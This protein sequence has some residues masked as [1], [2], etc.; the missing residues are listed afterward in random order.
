MRGVALVI[1]SAFFLSLFSLIPLHSSAY[2]D[3][4]KPAF[5][6]Q[7]Y[8]WGSPEARITPYP[9]GIEVPL[10]LS[11][12]DLL[13]FSISDVMVHVNL[14][15]GFTSPNGGTQVV[16]AY[17]SIP[18]LSQF[19]VNLYLNLPQSLRP[20][21]YS[22]PVLITWNNGT[23]YFQSSLNSTVFVGG[24]PELIAI[25]SSNVLQPGRTNGINLVLINEGTGNLSNL[26]LQ[27][28]STSPL[29]SILN[30]TYNINSLPPNSSVTLPFYL[31]VSSSAAGSPVQLQLQASYLDPY[32]QPQSLSTQL[33][34][35]VAQAEQPL[36]QFSVEPLTLIP[37]EVN[38][39]RLKVA[40]VGSGN[41]SGL[42]FS[43][44]S[45][46]QVSVLS[47]P[48]LIK[49]LSVGSTSALNLSVYAPLS[50]AGLGVVLNVQGTART[51]YGTI[52][53]SQLLD[54]QVSNSLKR[55]SLEI[56]ASPITLEPDRV[57]QVNLTVRNQ[58]DGSISNLQTEL[59]SSS[60]LYAVL[61]QP[62]IVLSLPPNSSVTLPFYLF[63]SS[64]AA[65]S[66]VQLQLQASY[67]DPYGQPQSLSTQLG[68]SVAQAEQSPV[69]VTV[70]QGKALIGSVSQLSFNLT[71][72]GSMS[73]EWVQVS[74]QIPAGEGIS[75]IPTGSLFREL[76]P[77]QTVTW[78]VPIAVSPNT[79]E[80]GYSATLLVDYQD[81]LGE[82][83]T[84]QFPV[85]FLV[86]GQ[87]RL[88]VQGQAVQ[89]IYS[90]PGR[91]ITVSGTL[92]NEGSTA[93]YYTVVSAYLEVNG[94]VISNS[95]TYVGEVETNTPLPFS[96]TLRY[97]GPP[98][99][100]KVLVEAFYQ[101][102]FGQ[103]FTINLT[104]F[105]VQFQSPPNSTSTT[106]SVSLGVKQ[107]SLIRLSLGIVILAA[108]I[109]SILYLRRR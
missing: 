79:P 13:N 88:S 71:N 63:V 46:S 5:Q 12:Q 84:S 47:G 102:D 14:S 95:S 8:F 30:S 6:F 101:N 40:N 83:L 37:G 53:V 50:V 89:Q 18:P 48:F 72:T 69:A 4:D 16:Q 58:G 70:T 51:D 22:F 15:N 57:Q 1:V 108:V 94:T 43:V 44:N 76:S 66:P 105:Q 34:F 61:A 68:F 33:G 31:F 54:L 10:T 49:E 19:Q 35:S 73:I 55:V 97:S 67:L 93:A 60:P 23:K 77:G 90:S 91:E 106:S 9:G 11:F 59:I 75:V 62:P 52:Q 36:L 2:Q 81:Q 27:L 100:G 74:L 104:D 24:S 82:H 3:Y 39:L 17:P 87:V 26:H 85:G 98:T 109:F 56:T 103:R 65:G 21:Y 80:G 20:G 32:G 25:T 96:L 45:Q 7:G 78:S 107:L 99:T 41:I 29:V 64:S 42:F 28:I 38:H 92:L 86:I